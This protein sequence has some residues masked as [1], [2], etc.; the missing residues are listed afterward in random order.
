MASS[1]AHAVVLGG[2]FAGLACAQKIREYAGDAVDITVIDRNPYLLFIPNIPAEV[3][4]GRDP[5][6]TLK[7]DTLRAFADAQATFIQGEVRAIDPD[8]RTIDFTPKER[9]GSPSETMGYDYLVVAF[10]C[11]L[12]YD[13]ITG[14]ASHAHAASDTYYG[15]KL[16]KTLFG[17]GYKGGPIAIG[18][19][20]F[21]QGTAVKDLVPMADAACEGPPVEIMMSMATWLKN[22]GLGG[23]D[24]ITVF[25]PGKMI[26]ED[27]GERVVNS[28]LGIASQMGF[29]YRNN[30]GDIAEVTHDGISFTQGDALDAE[31]K[32]LLPD[33][34]PHPFMKGLPICDEEGF[35]VTDMLMR[36]P[37]YPEILAC[38]DAAAVTVPKL[39]AIGHQES[40]IVGKQIAHDLGRLGKAAACEPLKPLV[41]CIGDMGDNQAF[42]IRSNSWYGGD[43]QVLKMGRVPYL[44][45]MQY[46][47]LFFRTQGKV[48]PWG[49]DAAQFL[50]E[51][52]FAA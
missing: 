45:K 8:T 18:S 36:N 19:A 41:Y 22:H 47:D 39:G 35:V 42:Y 16:R 33:W 4:E 27:A 49:L 12:A 31:L 5:A 43:T 40:E 25:T 46:K 17:G 44:L 6:A 23:P 51:R 28:L 48:P 1:K 9:E 26:A 21:H 24:K 15:N 34:V 37:K 30:V 3:F 11:R 50:A 13:K 14:F 20:R 10:G 2:N 52:L 7:M 38:G 29:H 32:I